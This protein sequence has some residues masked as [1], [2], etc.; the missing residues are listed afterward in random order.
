MRLALSVGAALLAAATALHAQ[1]DEKA[2]RGAAAKDKDARVRAAKTCEPTRPKGPTAYRDCVQ[3]ERCKATK[4]PKDC[5]ERY[6]KANVAHDKAAGACAGEKSKGE[7]PYQACM[8][9]ELCASHPSPMRCEM[10]AKAVH[11]CEPLKTKGGAYGDCMARE[12]CAQSDNKPRCEERARAAA[13]KAQG[14]E[15]SKKK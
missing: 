11:T 3:R 2:A 1:T 9:K 13:R 14:E 4:D 5:L 12:L 10:R 7:A 8:R 6:A 15:R